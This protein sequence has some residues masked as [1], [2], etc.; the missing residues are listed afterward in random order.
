MGLKCFI[1]L[2]AN[3]PFLKLITILKENIH[4]FGSILYDIFS[5]KLL[6]LLY[7]FQI[8][9][10][11]L[12]CKHR[13]LFNNKKGRLRSLLLLKGRLKPHQLA[14]RRIENVNI[15][16]LIQ[17]RKLFLYKIFLSIKKQR[18]TGRKQQYIHF[19]M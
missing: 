17:N 4:G 10:S 13:I 16:Y 11:I 15:L 12:L 3:L 7:K 18:K 2:N 1:F 9:I 19:K 14:Q 5:F 6:S 8:E